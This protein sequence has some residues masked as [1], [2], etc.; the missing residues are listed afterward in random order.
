MKKVNIL[1]GLPGSGKS[2]YASQLPANR[3]CSADNYFI[4][5][6]GVYQFERDKL[7]EAHK[8]CLRQFVKYL[9]S[10]N[11]ENLVVDN[12]NLDNVEISP[13]YSLA[14]AWNIPVTFV[15]FAYDIDKCF[16][17]N[18]HGV[19]RKNIE[20]MAERLNK[21]KLRPQWK[22]DLLEINSL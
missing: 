17:R 14:S 11:W 1:I 10:S 7:G 6:L 9:D 12:T 13:Y 5:E 19:P 20:V 22:Y 21:L 4:N 15:K 3:I 18:I 16:K 8:N 2:T